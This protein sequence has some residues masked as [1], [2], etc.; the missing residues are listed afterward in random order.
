[1]AKLSSRPRVSLPGGMGM[2]L[3]TG[4]TSVTH[5]RTRAGTGAYTRVGALYPCH[6]LVQTTRALLCLNNWS[7]LGLI[8]KKDLKKVASM[9]DVSSDEMDYEMKG[10]WDVV[11]EILD[12]D[13]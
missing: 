2:G 6:C 1:M 8:C 13:D 10:D 3:V 7:R 4:V 5:T 9:D 12:G 11:R